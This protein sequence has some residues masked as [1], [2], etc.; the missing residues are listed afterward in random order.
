VPFDP[1]ALPWWGWLLY[2]A[3]AGLLWAVSAAF[4]ERSL[5]GRV[6]TFVCGLLTCLLG[7]AA[8]V[9]FVRWG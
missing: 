2:S 7:V 8:L 1:T 4:A 9:V 5:L 6:I 3:G